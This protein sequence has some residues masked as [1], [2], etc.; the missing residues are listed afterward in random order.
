MLV[1]VVVLLLSLKE[2][3]AAAGFENRDGTVGTPERTFPA[4][5]PNA[6]RREKGISKRETRGR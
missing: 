1:L 5:S 4:E 2:P 6:K 3:L